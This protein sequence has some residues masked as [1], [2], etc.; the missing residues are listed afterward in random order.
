[1]SDKPSIT[2]SCKSRKNHDDTKKYKVIFDLAA[3]A[4]FI[5]NQQG[6]FTEVNESALLLTGYTREELLAKTMS[7]LFAD[8]ELHQSPLRYDLL[9]EGKTIRADRNLVKK[10]GTIIPI[11]M[12]SRMLPNGAL[13]AVIRDISAR[14]QLEQSLEEH[15][16]HQQNIIDAAFEAIG[17]FVDGICVIQNKRAEELFGYTIEEAIGRPAT[18][19]IAPA[20]RERVKQK[21]LFGV[22]DLYESV[23]IHKDGSEF[24]IDIQARITTYNGK[25]ARITAARD[26]TSRKKAEND[27]LTLQKLE[28]IGTLAGGLDHDL[29]NILTGLFGNLS[30]ARIHLKE[31]DRA[32]QFIEKAEES[33]TRFT[34]ITNKLLTFSK[35]GQPVTQSVNLKDL[36]QDIVHFDLAGSNVIA[37]LSSDEH[38]WTARVDEGQIQQVFSNLIINANQA[39]PD[40]GN[41]LIKLF[42]TDNTSGIISNLPIGLYIKIEV[43]DEGKGIHPDNLVNIF[44]PYFTTKEHGSGL[45]LTSVHSIV[46]KHG[47]LISASSVVDKGTRF[48]VYLPAEKENTNKENF[49]ETNQ[50]TQLEK[51][52]RILLMDDDSSVCTICKNLLESIKCPVSV[53]H[54]TSEAIKLFSQADKDEIPFDI[55][56]LDLTI[57]GE[58]GG[59]ETVKELL[60]IN[61][62]TKMV[63]SSGYSDNPVMANYK[64]YGFSAVLAKPYTLDKLM[65]MLQSL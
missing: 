7:S 32:Y 24:P 12:N 8:D 46:S 40:G 38:L 50:T 1:M 2:H 5:G 21:I 37:H 62:R 42:N 43:D 3:D 49:I 64:E 36:I 61:K 30:L 54:N 14:I 18:D 15:L 55:A 9:F 33:L 26:I 56:I 6:Q 11:E 25:P 28:S 51:P 10:D 59:I 39:M 35:G 23:G 44:D 47:G 34:R 41:L 48:T 65:T 4:I 45:G 31:E 16:K 27:L 13:Q 17:I 52:F 53:A 20:E 29:N 63:V 19:W 60:A 22:E 58:A 57:P